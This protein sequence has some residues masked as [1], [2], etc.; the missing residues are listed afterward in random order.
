MRKPSPRNLSGGG[1][2]HQLLFFSEFGT[3]KNRGLSGQKSSM[4]HSWMAWVSSQGFLE[5]LQ[6]QASPRKEKSHP[7]VCCPL[8]GCSWERAWWAWTQNLR[9]WKIR[10]FFGFKLER[11]ITMIYCY[12]KHFWY[13]M[14]EFSTPNN[15]PV[16]CRHQLGVLQ[17]NSILTLTTWS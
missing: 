4:N 10:R 13:Q 11:L 5:E 16:L 6:W 15:Y 2:A 12:S 14:G 3:A 17:F 1:L 9:R 7:L 8:A